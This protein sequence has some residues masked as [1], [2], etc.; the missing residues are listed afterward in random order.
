M[1]VP[2]PLAISGAKR[3]CPTQPAS[4]KQP[5]LSLNFRQPCDEE[6]IRA[7]AVGGARAARSGK[8]VLAATILGSSMAFIDGT[9]VSVALPVLQADL[10]A[11]VSQLQWVVE[12]YALFLAALL[13]VGGSLGD[14]LGRRRAFAWG[15]GIFTLASIW[16]G[17][18]PTAEQLIAAR[19]VQ[20]IGAA[21]LVPGSLTIISASFD[22]SAAERPSVRGPASPPSPRP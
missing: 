16:C 4:Q 19:A 3:W 9:A 17:L 15:V 1:L 14:R 8:W 20:G 22:E 12:S 7:G 10:S 11:S 6:A 21:L 18:A 5:P 13:L 2:A